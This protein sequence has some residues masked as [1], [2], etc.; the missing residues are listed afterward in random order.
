MDNFSLFGNRDSGHAYKVRLML[1]LS[2]L[3]YDYTEID[4]DLPRGQRPEPFR[5][6]AKYGEVPLLLHNGRPYVQSNAI[7]LHLAEH[8]G[9]FGGESAERMERMR[10]WLFWEANR[11]GFSLANL[12]YGQKYLPAGAASDG[13]AMLRERFNADIA[14]LDDELSDGRA[15][16]MDGTPS[17][18]DISLCGY[19]YWPEQANVTMPANVQGWLDRISALPGW[20]HPYD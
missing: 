15:F 14:R 5:S 13:Q 6:Q 11:V 12:R 20:R 8:T 10:E 4:L 19:M 1:S 18:A 2:G 9:R 3:A 17:I 16:I 7:L